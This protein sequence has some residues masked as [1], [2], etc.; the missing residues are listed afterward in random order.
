MPFI[1]LIV[2]YETAPGD[3]QTITTLLNCEALAQ[4]S[5]FV[6]VDHSRLDQSAAC[7]LAC[8][9]LPRPVIYVHDPSNPPLGSAY[10]R[11]IRE[12]LGEAEY[13]LILD[14]DSTL[15]ASFLRTAIDAARAHGG[16]SL[17]VPTIVTADRI[18]S[19]CW[20]WL[21]W[22]FPWR[23]ADSGWHSLRTCSAITSGCWIHRRVFTTGGL[24][25]DERL[26]LYGIETDFF[27]R[28]ARL[29]A[30]FYVLPVSLQHSMS[31]DEATVDVKARKLDQ[32]F[33]SHRLIFE[34]D[35]WGTRTLLALLQLAVRLKY[36]IRYRSKRFLPLPNRHG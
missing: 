1:L 8:A 18:A 5:E 19:P 28:L 16:P 4:C 27:R 3:A 33:A 36:A 15:P 29:D 13:A 23:H 26:Q 25:F 7:R 31:F 30:R 6:V 9:G 11:V 34:N 20:T 24:W 10:N 2:L 14:Q 12:H 22:G 17:M 32:I 35:G 21:T